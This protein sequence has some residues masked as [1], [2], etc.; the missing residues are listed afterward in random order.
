MSDAPFR[1]PRLPVDERVKDLLSRLEPTEKIALLHQYAPAVPRLGLAAHVTGTEALHGVAWL[2]AATSFPQAVGL[3]AT[4]NPELVRAVGE[5]VSTEVRAFHE[6]PPAPG[7]EAPISLNVWAPVVNPLRHPLWGRNEEGYAECPLLTAELA[8]AYAQGLRGDHPVYWRTAPTLKHFLGYNN[9]TDRTT[10]SS[11]LRQ[12]VLHEYELPCYRGPVESGAIAAVMP[13]YNVVNGRPAHVSGYLKDELRRWKHGADLLV[14][15]DA[16]A[17]SNL[18]AAQRHYP[19]HATGHAAALRAGVDSFTDHGADPQVTAA[20]FTE[21]L[22]RGLVDEA[23]ID[24]AVARL[25]TLRIRT[26]E[27]DPGLDPYAGTGQAV[28]DCPEHRALARESARQAVVLLRNEDALLPLAP[29][30]T[31]AVVGPLGDDVLRDWYSGSLTHRTTLLDALRA[32]LGAERVT[33]T[34]GLDRIALRSTTTGG[35][36]GAGP[37]G[38]LAATAPAVGGSEVFAV[39]D[40]GRGVTTV[41]AHDG[42]Y[43]TKDDYGLL[44]AT[45]DHPDAWVVQEAFRLERGEDGRTR[46]QHLGSGRWIAVAA[47]TGALTTCTTAYE[48]AEPFVCRLVSAGAAAAA[49]IAA[50]ADTV[51]VV[52]GNDPHLNGRETE[53]R[54]DLALP[55]QQEEL[56]RTARAANPRTVLAVVSGHPYAVDW[57]AREVPAVLWT[58]HG[59]QE[60]GAALADVLLGDAAPTGRLPQ[61][62]YRAGQPL[63]GLLDYDIIAGRLTYQYLDEEPL[64]PFGHGLGYTAF[65]YGPLRV[66]LDDGRVVAALTVTNT[67]RRAGTETVQLYARALEAR[68]SAPLRL[69]A[70]R[71]VQLAPGEAREVEFAVPLEAL[72][73]RD[74]AHH[75]WAAP[76]GRQLLAAAASAGD[77]RSTAELAL[78][79]AESAPR[80]AHGTTVLARDFNEAQGARIVERSRAEG[81]EAVEGAGLARLLF[82]D[83][84]LGGRAGRIRL[85]VARALPGSAAVE[86]ELDGRVT[87]VPVPSTGGPQEWTELTAGLAA[88]ASGVHDVRLTLRG[89]LRLDR[90]GFES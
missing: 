69:H 6:R 58:A 56:L 17:P 60:G 75:R 40:W 20:R 74:V 55:P 59:G 34:D 72:G 24:A 31:L 88:P 35:Y 87:T 53:D 67:G 80:P 11:D 16:E 62:W 1:D 65:G 47:G 78:P 41:Q 89:A 25:L 84:D 42:R 66:S 12:R 2:G 82:H 15:S 48:E 36:L 68:H 86:V 3:G 27:L 28:V 5:A 22:E 54:V 18:V 70:F 46:I 45:A 61:T 10:S 38:L 4:W 30:G 37:D 79:A 26:G 29:T 9:E 52:A 23:D 14:C 63:P 33:H 51:V 77:L 76:A 50:A 73:H 7:R 19:D 32:R 83:C 13:S 64:Y 57:A 43:L 39:Q 85:T 81:G 90:F 71:R 21:A 49:R 8:T 44:A